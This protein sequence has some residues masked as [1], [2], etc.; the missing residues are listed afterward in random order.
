MFTLNK[1]TTVDDVIEH[2]ILRLNTDFEGAYLELNQFCRYDESDEDY[3]YDKKMA[4]LVL[5]KMLEY[6]LVKLA[7]HGFDRV[8]LRPNG[9]KAYKSGGWK[10]YLNDVDQ[11]KA[12]KERLARQPKINVGGNAIIGDNNSNNH[13]GLGD[14]ESS[15]N[16]TILEPTINAAQPKKED[17]KTQESSILN[18]IYKWTD[19]KL[20]SGIILLILGFFISRFFIWLGLLSCP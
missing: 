6:D 9:I 13:L 18:K 8:V 11:L 10:K 14:L 15:H 17:Q 4:A 7:N 5:D 1:D 19:H 20:I 16:S 3:D 2:I 12:E